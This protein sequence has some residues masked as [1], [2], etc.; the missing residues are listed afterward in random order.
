M[1]ILSGD[2]PKGTKIQ[3][4][5]LEALIDLHNMTGAFARNLQ[6]LFSKSD[7]QVLLSTL[8]A[9]YSPYESFKQRYILKLVIVRNLN[10]SYI[11][12]IGGKCNTF[13]MVYPNP[14]SLKPAQYTY[15]R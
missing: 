8:K 4:K 9:V 13:L 15:M 6:H 12:K 11:G 2:M 1:D 5:H 10:G 14:N 7:I 3:D